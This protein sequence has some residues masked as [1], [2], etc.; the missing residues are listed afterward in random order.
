MD[1]DERQRKLEAGRAKFEQYRQQRAKGNTSKKTAKKK[2]QTVQTNERSAQEESRP[3]HSHG[4]DSKEELEDSVQSHDA[5]EPEEMNQ[6]D[7]QEQSSLPVDRM[8]ADQPDEQEDHLDEIVITHTSREQL[9]QLQAAVEKRNQIISQLSVNLQAA[10]MSRDQVQLEAQQLTGQ[11]QELQQQL[12]QA[13]EYLRSKSVG[14]LDLSQT[15]RQLHIEHSLQMRNDQKV[16]LAQKETEI[17]AL[18]QT[19]TVMKDSLAQLQSAFTSNNMEQIKAS[20]CHNGELLSGFN[21]SPENNL[22]SSSDLIQRL[23]CELDEERQNS[24][25]SQERAENLQEMVLK[26]ERDKVEMEARLQVIQDDLERAEKQTREA[27]QYKAE[28][29][30]LNQDVVRLDGLVQELQNRLREE[31]EKSEC[32][33]SKYE[34]EIT[35]CE[36]RLQTL[37]EERVLNVAQLS[38]AHE[39]ALKRLQEEHSEDVKQIRE[40]LD[41]VQKH[42][43]HGASSELDTSVTWIQ[44]SEE[45]HNQETATEGSPEAVPSRNASVTDDLMERYLASAVQRE[46]SW[47]EQ[48]LEERS[49]MENST[50]SKLEFE[51]ESRFLVHLD[52]GAHNTNPED[53]SSG[54]DGM[55]FTQAQWQSFNSTSNG[56]NESVDL[57]K[58]L[59]IQQCGDLTKQLEEKERQL[60]IL[61]EEVRRSAE[62]LEE[63]RERWS[64]ASEE[65]EEAKWELET[66]RD[67][68]LHCEELLNEK[69]HEQDN[70]KNK[71]SYLES[72]KEKEQLTSSME[73]DDKNSSTEELLK[74]LKED[75]VKLVLQLKHQEQLVRDIQEQKMA[76]DSVSCEVQA[77]F[78]RQLSSLQAQ[79]DQLMAQLETQRGKNQTSSVLLG[80]KTLEVDSAYREIQQLRAEVEERVENVQRLEKV[81]VDLESKLTCLKENLSNMEEALRQGSAEKAALEKRLQALDEQNKSMEKVLET[82][83]EN[84]ELQL[85]AKDV[86]LEQMK[87]AREKAEE[88]LMEKDSALQKELREHEEEKK[89]LEEKHQQEVLDWSLR[90]EK[91][92]SVLRSNLEEEQKKQITLIKQV[93]EREHQREMAEQ[94]SQRREELD[95]LK[96][97]LSEELRDSMEAAH[98]A[99]LSQAQTQHALELEALRLSLTNL[100]TAQLELTQSNLQKE[101][102]AALSELQASLREKWAQESAMLQTRQ[103]FE[104]ERLREQSREQSREQERQAELQLQLAIDDLNCGWEKRISEERTSLEQQQASR[105]EDAKAQWFQDSKKEQ[106]EL[107]AA[108][109]KAEESLAEMQHKLEELQRSKEEEIKHL[110]SE[111]SQAWSD[112]DSAARAVEELV[113]SHKVV[114]QEQQAQTQELE[115]KEKLLKQEVDRLLTEQEAQ[116][117]SSEQEIANLWSQLES[118]R[119]SRQELGELKEQLLARTSRVD[120]I[121]R[122]KQDFSQQRRELQEQN[123]A[124]LENLR[125]YFEQRLRAS[126][127]NH[128]EEIALLQLR[129][130]EGALEDS[131]LK[132]GDASFLSEEKAEEER[133]D[134]LAEITEQLEKHKVELDALRLQLEEKHTQDLE[135]LRCSMALS[136][137][138]ELLQARSE[139]T[140][141]YYS[142]ME[143]LKTKHA[144]EIEQLRAKLSDSHLKEITKL[145]LQ[146]VTDVA[147][148]VEA[149]LEEKTRLQTQEHQA[150]LAQLASDTERILSLEKELAELAL[151]HGRELERSTERHVEE[152]RELEDRLKKNF[153]EELRTRLAEAQQEERSRVTEELSHRSSEEQLQLREQLQAQAE[154]RM[155]S[156]REELQQAANEERREL[157]QKLA[158]AEELLAE[159]KQ[160]L[161]ALQASLESEESPQVVALKQRL[162]AQYASEL[163]TAKSTMAAEVKELNALLREQTESRVQEA[164]CRHQEEQRQLVEKLAQQREED[165]QKQ[166]QQHAQELQAQTALLEQNISKLQHLQKEYQEL[167]TQ[168]QDELDLLSSNHKAALDSLAEKHRAELDKLQVVLQETNEAQLEAQEAELGAHHK[169]EMEELETRMLCNMDTLESTYLTEIQA[170]REEKEDALRELRAS[171]EQQQA[172]E[173][174]RVK[175]E[176]LT[177][178]EE[179]RKELARVHMDKFSAMATELSHAHQAEL[180]AAL[181]SQKA[182]LESDHHSALET[183][184]QHVLDLETQHSAALHEVSD[185]TAKE[186]QQLQQQLDALNAQHQQQLQELRAT[187]SREIEALRR[188]LEEEASRQR[189]HFLEEA[190]LLKCQSEEQLQQKIAQLKEES[191]QEKTAALDELE[192]SLREQH[193]QNEL[194][195][196]DKMNQLTAQL[197]QLDTVVSQLRAEVSGLQGELEGKRSEMDTLETLLQR[198][199]RESQEG[200]NLLTMLRDD[201]NTATQ[202][203]QDLQ[204]AHDRLQQLF[205][206]MLRITIATEEEIGRRLGICVDT[207]CTGGNTPNRMP[208]GNRDTQETADMDGGA[209]G[210]VE[211]GANCSVFSSVIDE[212]L[213]LSQRLCESLFSGP[214]GELDPEREELVLGACTRLRAAVDKL[215]ELVSDS[216]VQLEQLRA[217]QVVLDEQFSE[218]GEAKNA[219]LQQH[220]QL[221]EQ[222][223]QEASVK[224][225][226]QLELHKAEGLMEGYVAEKA[227]LEEALQQKEVREQR[228]VEELESTRVQLQ[229]LGEE[230]ALL[231]RQ[232]DALSAG[233]GEPEKGCP[234]VGEEK[235][236]LAETERL[237]QERVDVQRQAEKDRVGLAG[238]LRFLELALEEQESRA[239]Q[240]EEQHRTQTEDLQQHI[241]ALEKQLKHHRQFI[242]E[243][244]VEREHERDEFQQEIKNLEAQLRMPSKGHT[245]VDT[246]GQRI[247]DLVIQVESLQALIKDKTE[248]YSV[249]LSVKE[250]CQR[251]LEDRNEEIDK[252]ASRIR[253]LEQAL[254]SSVEAGRAVTQLEQELQKA[255]KSLQELSQDKEALQQQLYSNKL[256]IS[257]LQSKLDETRHRFPDP[258]AD[259]NLREQLETLQQDLQNKEEQV[260]VLLERVEALEKSLAVKEE[261]IRQLSLQLELKTNESRAREEELHLRITELQETVSTLRRQQQEE[262][263]TSAL[264]LPAALLEEKNLEIDHLNQQLLRLQ[265]ELDATKE[266]KTAEEKQADIED[267]RAQVERLRGDQERLRQAKEEEA[268]Q[269]HEVIHKLQEELSQLDP[270]R[271]EV[272]DP[273]TDSPEPPDFPWSPRPQHGTEESL[274]HEL[275]SQTLQSCRNK[276]SEVQVD[277]ERSVEEKEALQRLLL[278]QEEQYGQQVEALGRS[279][280]EERGRLVILEQ[281]AGELKLQL[282]QK[283]VEV[284]N[285]QDHIRKLENGEKNLKD[286]EL[287]LKKAEER[288]KEAQQEM[289]RLSEEAQKHTEERERLEGRL[290]ELQQKSEDSENTVAQMRLQVTELEEKLQQQKSDVA[291]LETGKKELYMEKQVLQRREAKLQEEIEKLKQEVSAKS[292]QIQELNMQLEERATKQEETQ[293]EVLTCAEE[294]LAKAEAALREKEEQLAHLRLQ[295]D[296]LRAELAAVKEGLSTSTERAEKLQ[297]EGQTKDRALADLEEHNQHLRA[298]LRGLQ[299]DL[300]VQEEEL[301]YQQRELEELRQRCSHQEHAELHGSKPEQRFLDGLSHDSS[302]SS[303][304]VLR[305]LECSEERPSHLHAS[306]LSELSGLRSTSLELASKH[307]PMERNELKRPLALLPET[308]PPSTR[309]PSASPRSL[310]ICE[311]L[312]VLDSLDADKVQ[313]LENLD[314]VTPSRS[315]SRSPLSSTSPVSAPE[316]ASDGYGS[317][318]SSELE[319]KLKH[320]LEH[321]ER[322][323]AHFVDYLRSRDMA[324]ASRSDSAAGSLHHTYELLS[325]ELQAMLNRVYRESCRVL[326]LSHRPPPAGQPQPDS[327]EAPPPSW[328]RERRALQETVLSLRELLCRMAEREPKVDG[329]VDWRRELLQAVR[330]VFDS[331]RKWLHAQLQD[332]MATNTGIDYTSLLKHLEMLLQK[333]EEQQ[334]RSL[335][336]LLSAD[337]NSLLAEIRSLHEQLHACTLQSQEQLRE[338]QSSLNAVRDES[339]QTQQQLHRQ[340]GELERQLQQEQTASQEVRRSL[341][342]EQSRSTNQHHQLEA[343][344]KLV[345]EMKVELEERT[346]QLHLASKTQEELQ[347][348]IHKLRLKVESEEQEHQA[349]V[350]AAEREQTRVKQLQEELHHERLNSKHVQEEHAHTQESLRSSLSEHATRLSELNSALEQERVAVSN[351]R[352]ELQI[353]QSRCEALLAQERERTEL[354]L[355]RL[356][357]ERSRTAELSRTLSHQAQEHARRLEEEV[358]SQEAA[359]AHDRKFIQEL[360]AQLEQ[361]R[362]QA[363][364]LAATVDRLQ[365]Q[366]LQ[367]KRRQEE[368]AQ[369][370]AQRGQEEVKRLRSALE[371]LQAQR[372]E[373]SRTLETERH[374]ASQLQ[375]ELDAMKEKMREVK[376]KERAREEQREKQRWREK[377]EQED[378]ERRQERTK[379]KLLELEALRER[380]QQRLRQLQQTL[381]DLEQQEKRLTSERLHRDLHT[382]DSTRITHTQDSPTSSSS[383]SLLERVL[384]E[385]SELAERLAAL[386]EEKISL[387]H[388]ITCLERDLHN[389]KRSEQSSVQLDPSVL[390]EKLVWQKEKVALQAALHKAEDDLVKATARNENRPITDL[391]NNK[392][393]RLYEKYLRA[394]SY[395]KSLVYQKRYL[396]LLLGGFQDCEQATLA[397]IARMG[398]QPSLISQASRPISRFRSAVRALIA[399]SRLKFLTRKW[400]RATKKSSVGSVTV[401]SA[402]VRTEVLKPQQ[403]GAAFNSPPTRDRVLTQRTAVS[404]LVPPVKSPFRLHNG[405]YSSSI[406]APSERTLT[407]SQEQERSLTDYIHH[408]ESV[409]Q[410]LGA[411]RPVPRDERRRSLPDMMGFRQKWLHENRSWLYLSCLSPGYM[412]P[413]GS[414]ATFPFPRKTDR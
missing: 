353:E 199:E 28:K 367:G 127:E 128:R 31:E 249:L 20:L 50:V 268:E 374:R 110:E 80:Q 117:A 378:K 360:R 214:D 181:A 285:L 106:S 256:Q 293:K 4:Q 384:K 64:K 165:L 17:T 89:R 328:Q 19:L 205:L 43:L 334:R 34:A 333:Q 295:H 372:A 389:L 336:Q 186:K 279:L 227:A 163:R 178:R 304:E 243:Q 204:L 32:L 324:P 388:T 269:L 74:D 126:E 42:D 76:G 55:S 331:E 332:V 52:S 35:N 143:Q 94:G 280:G 357:E 116:K 88:E 265:Q 325:P 53:Q 176:E 281:E 403:S 216:T 38:E 341:V 320:E 208:S 136:Y 287:R 213:E 230:H 57:G 90:L 111:L 201:L 81:R 99:E 118:M 399:I 130:V 358:R 252:M 305:R 340:V 168:H 233:L 319:A 335:E 75:K 376:E 122:L 330:S 115:E 242:D 190:E 405:G 363:E 66:E 79:R 8:A 377:Q 369:Q 234:A 302:L 9:K 162:E 72:Q 327:E 219:L 65:L 397:L 12:Q 23:K 232:R 174:E 229:E 112:R 173:M 102:E 175:Q 198:R 339:V 209:V 307:S 344:Q 408:L 71:L 235:A 197:Q 187:S 148:Q 312:S 273:N 383:S 45:H 290:A 121:E 277:L 29:E 22:D 365:A 189:L 160:R 40:L 391:S 259:P 58:E 244:A 300:E 284:G 272:S 368:A 240:Q 191:E 157:E 381:A 200:A 124:E 237:G 83:L 114:L 306:H 255:R 134:S 180:S 61:Q 218:G 49:I 375:T 153:A 27:Q 321:T 84:F 220:T 212:G 282:G 24:K 172:I 394:E 166:K 238:R 283:E 404:P 70:L 310:S 215:L 10:L 14:W 206:E 222:L 239:Q 231:Q 286:L 297:E 39:A 11:I 195:Y 87:E 260:E 44:T 291:I 33:R 182:A 16:L 63:A 299:D 315:P 267:L 107:Q 194:C 275:S 410:R 364:E 400:Q 308:D 211:G 91:E 379:E 151:Q 78:G 393:Q 298:E 406:L 326:S 253:E 245:G 258:S 7:S 361:E 278:T 289:T 387:K 164:T 398:A 101:K 386:S 262:G 276:L 250:Q 412:W 96:A 177:I 36:L 192:R 68:R 247:E 342:E 316:W 59:L 274:C 138:E 264:Q 382:T 77:L 54:L 271:H 359:S 119:T 179:L 185:M 226:L 6:T 46:S 171:L 69:I 223:D 41:Q 409:Q 270:N 221:L 345:V 261:D 257:A 362:R 123:E 193:Q 131:A 346:Q 167:K 396:L 294:T 125:V 135:Q 85:R 132:T 352:A 373:V 311:N 170:V 2:S 62:E 139:L 356:D 137:R 228:L 144:L 67:K 150:R 47:M 156:L 105:I 82:E 414:P 15:H 133:G 411:V 288:R 392:V 202:Q 93:H 318:V 347:A 351:L 146:S 152:L 337:R 113:A 73:L 251:D 371:G 184:R 109:N 1:L 108:L 322:L 407:P 21:T 309:S 203:R 329:D 154:E 30:R 60:D 303:P 86:D 56:L 313:E 129:L 26:F 95:L 13:K 338:L 296:A 349:C 5:G 158:Q 51:D 161:H 390:S 188:E 254:L 317:N 196:T 141:R 366:V 120:D 145:R 169:Q 155:A 248:D 100:H 355:S 354:A 246:K 413:L 97:E 103:Q 301:A 140:D 25:R 18:Q 350:E 147:R 266:N 348:Q 142:D 292:I 183:L 395:R 159:E 314:D 92:L 37:E 207:D 385:N 236:L 370:E 380:D 217:L 401:N 48:S 402:A 263:D 98:Q 224:S 104:L 210:A 343:E 225:Q 149:E 323:D 3:E 241:N